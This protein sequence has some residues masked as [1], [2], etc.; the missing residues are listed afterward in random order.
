MNNKKNK[1]VMTSIG[2]FVIVAIVACIVIIMTAVSKNSSGKSLDT[3][4]KRVDY[5]TAT[6]K[7]ASINISDTSL[8]DEL[9][10]INKYPLAVEGYGQVDI[11]IFTS[12]E[13]AGSGND[14]WLIDC[15]DRIN[16][17][18]IQ[19]QSGK[20]VSVS[21]RSVSSGLAADYI[22]SGKYL[23]DLYTPSNQLFGEYAIAN[24][25][26]LELY[27]ERLVG[28]TAGILV[29]KNSGYSDVEQVIQDV[30]DGK[31]NIGYTNPQTSATGLNLLIEILKNNGNG[32]VMADSAAEA[33]AK[34]NN[35][36]PFVAYTTQQMA[37][38]ASNGTLDGMVTEYQAYVND[39]NLKSTYEF[40]PFGLRHD[41]PVYI[42]DKRSKSSDEVEA[43]DLIVEFLL[44]DECQKI[45][46]KYGFNQNEEYKDAY[47]V[48]GADVTQSLN[49]YKAQKDSGNDII[50]VFVADCSGSMDGDAINE[51]KNSLS[52]GMQYINANNY[53]GLVSYNNDVTIEVPI[54]PFDLNQKS[55]FQGAINGLV[56][57][58][59]T[60]SYEAICVGLKMIEDMRVDHPDAKCMLFLLSDGKANGDYSLHDIES[61]VKESSVPIY[62]IGYTS[63]ADMNSLGMLSDINEAACISADSDDI[64]Y[65]IKSLFNAQL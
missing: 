30:M 50:A 3:L 44:S 38:S 34:F 58:G 57:N 17:Q 1:S 35:N 36:I 39:S 29:R 62:T 21:V 41:N 61:A 8:Y 27:S 48:S 7:K 63:M 46:T 64:V 15:A 31:L 49:V 4:L 55:Y 32:D 51:L 65:K 9:P 59:G 56:A 33:F 16:A 28:N 20:T 54:A 10:E 47:S 40:I 60:S 42:V 2:A 52:N 53:V 19:T 12:G 45:A 14:S 26:N 37:D 6:P 13:K 23:P 5:H 18:G 25:A 24:G 11:E 43:I 22:I